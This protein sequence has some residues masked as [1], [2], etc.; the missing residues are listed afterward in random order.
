MKA[1]LMHQFNLIWSTVSRLVED[2]KM[3]KSHEMKERDEWY[4]QG[5]NKIIE[6]KEDD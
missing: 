3:N 2:E 1:H 5:L 6:I 4:R